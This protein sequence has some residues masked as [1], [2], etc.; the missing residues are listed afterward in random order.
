[1]QNLLSCSILNDGLDYIINKNK[2]ARQSL[3]Y[4]FIYEQRNK[5]SVDNLHSEL[6]ALE[7]WHKWYTIVYCKPVVVCPVTKITY[8]NLNISEV[9]SIGCTSPINIIEI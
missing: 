6:G 3:R 7:T 2:V 1:M 9:E 4:R 5:L 8:C